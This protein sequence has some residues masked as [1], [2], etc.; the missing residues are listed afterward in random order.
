MRRIIDRCAYSLAKGLANQLNENHQKR[1]VYYYGFQ[2]VIGS[3]AKL[4]LLA[5]ISAVLGVFFPAVVI[6]FTF[7]LLRIIAGG[8]HLD[9]FGKCITSSLILIITGGLISRYTFEYWPF[10]LLAAFLAIVFL[11]SLFIMIKWAPADSPNKPITKPEEIKKFKTWSIVFVLAWGALV[12][13]LVAFNLHMYAIATGYGLIMQSF[14]VTP[15]GYRWFEAYQ[16][17]L[18]GAKTK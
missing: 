9:T 15:A 1:S 13:L 8:V 11:S 16:D 7:A 4:T 5:V 3:A 18:N 2:I 17:K 6:L 10:E 12:S 14:T